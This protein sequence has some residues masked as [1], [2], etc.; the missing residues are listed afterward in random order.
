MKPFDAGDERVYGGDENVSTGEQRV[1]NACLSFS[2]THA[3]THAHTCTHT[4]TAGYQ[5][6]TCTSEMGTFTFRRSKNYI[7]AKQYVW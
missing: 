1:D 5:L 3:R 4:H 7:H 6:L 2:R